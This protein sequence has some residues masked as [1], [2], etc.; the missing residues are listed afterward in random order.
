MSAE[1]AAQ[2]EKHPLFHDFIR[3][4]YWD[5]QAKIANMPVEEKDIQM[6]KELAAAHLAKQSH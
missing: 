4:R 3:I 6:I 1:E 2:Y 5:D